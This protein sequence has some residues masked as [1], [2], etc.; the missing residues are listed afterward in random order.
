[1]ENFELKSKIKYLIGEI[2][3]GFQQVEGKIGILKID[4]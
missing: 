1:M 2:N 4:Y 3:I